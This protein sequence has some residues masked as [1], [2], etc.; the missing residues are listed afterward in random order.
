MRTRYTLAIYCFF[1]CL[2]HCFSLQASARQTQKDIENTF[3]NITEKI[4]DNRP[5]V[6]IN[7]KTLSDV[8][9]RALSAHHDHFIQMKSSVDENINDSI[10]F[11]DVNITDGTQSKDH[12]YGFTAS[13]AALV[14]LVTGQRAYLEYTKRVLKKL[15]EYYNYRNEHK[16]NVNWYAY[17]RICALTAY[18]WIY[19]DLTKSERIELGKPLLYAIN[20]MIPD[21]SRPLFARENVGDYKTGYYGP[22]A[23][24][25]YAGL[26]FYKT[27]IDDVLAY[28]LLKKGFK[29]HWQLLTYRQ[30]IAG[31]DGGASSAVMEYAIQAY[32]W[33]EFNFFHS[34]NS[35]TDIDI[36]QQWTF[37]LDFLYYVAWNWLPGSRHFGYGD[38]DHFNNKL[39]LKHMYVHLAQIKHFYQKKHPEAIPL[40]KWI[41]ERVTQQPID[42]I[43]F[44][45]YLLNDGEANATEQKNVKTSLAALPAAMFFEN[46][47]QLFMRSGTGD[48]DTYALFSAGG[49][50]DQHRHY[51]NNNFVIYKKG[52]RTV[53]AGTR[54]EPGQHLTHY[55]CR[56]VAH[57][58]ILIRMPEEKFP[59]YWGGPAS[60]ETPLPIPND[61]GQRKIIGSKV[62]GYSQ[63][64]QYV[65]IASDATEAYHS[66][67]ATTVIRQFVFVQPDVFVVF[68][69]VVSKSADYPKT[70]L[71]HTA[72]EPF[73]INN[74]EFFEESDGGKLFCRT[75]FPKEG[76]L[77]KI[78]GE[79]KQFWSDGRNWPLPILTPNDWN[80]RKSRSKVPLDTIPLLGQ[81][82]IEVA[83]K[84]PKL[85]DS[86]LHIMQVGDT[87]MENMVSSKPIEI[88]GK[89]G[90]GFDYNGKTYQILFSEETST[91]GNIR[92]SKEKKIL[93]DQ[94]L[95]TKVEDQKN[96]FQNNNKK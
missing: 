40:I 8:K 22:P 13:N 61:G 21:G 11:K 83:P 56:T 96:V 66:D 51:D 55:Y 49:L 75:V 9:L 18:D 42:V 69:K 27:G 94:P 12:E 87:S 58:C 36:S 4:R 26:V 38:V 43:P 7:D 77:T 64:S 71:L 53:D 73:I 92:I 78:G 82:R 24:A 88:D 89:K 84:L 16:L 10:V 44:A 86:F 6:F 50:L 32:P 95:T 45:R 80:Y 2:L 25:W 46:M 76:Q 93:L 39:P 41:G 30:H 48:D 15:A 70:W 14:Y 57:N 85:K 63:N 3:L 5:R 35:A 60:A 91:G 1:L 20:T 90:V 65:Y 29:E 54:P 62:I 72:A 74:D 59:E 37:P 23:L 28:K 19:S 17:S 31:D 52:F 34:V 67:K 79:G 81:W 47:G 33:A 68:D